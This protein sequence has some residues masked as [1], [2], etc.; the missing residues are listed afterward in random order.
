MR[1]VTHSFTPVA[2]DGGHWLARAGIQGDH[3]PRR[4]PTVLADGMQT[5]ARS[6]ALFRG[7]GAY[8][9]NRPSAAWK[10]CLGPLSNKGSEVSRRPKAAANAA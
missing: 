8:W 10:D 1:A 3:L 5:V 6:K 9:N 2:R 4:T 7:E